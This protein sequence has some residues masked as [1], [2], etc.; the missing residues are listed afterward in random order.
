[1]SIRSV[2]VFCLVFAAPAFCQSAA[3]VKPQEPAVKIIRVQGDPRPIV[4]LVKPGS[5]AI[6]QW[7]SALG[8]IV[9]RGSPSSVASAERV[10]QEL[11]SLNGNTQSRDIELIVHVLGGV[12]ADGASARS[13]S[14]RTR[15]LP[16]S[17]SSFTGRFHSS[18]IRC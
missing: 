15:T 17:I 2:A 1:M 18:L 14:P 9:L 12:P 4:E 8:V 11:E 3:E 13:R 5:N 10:I 7:D 16:L 6:I